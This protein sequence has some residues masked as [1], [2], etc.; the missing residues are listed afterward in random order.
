MVN[1]FHRREKRNME[2]WNNS[3]MHVSSELSKCSFKANRLY[4]EPISWAFKYW[5]SGPREPPGAKHRTSYKEALL[6]ESRVKV[7]FVS[8]AMQREQ[9]MA[10]ELTELGLPGTIAMMGA[11]ERQNPE[12]SCPEDCGV[13]LCC[14]LNLRIVRKRYWA[15]SPSLGRLSGTHHNRTWSFSSTA[16]GIDQWL[17]HHSWAELRNAAC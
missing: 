2:K 17:S 11:L 15:S 7:D 3:M 8:R 6:H 4:S 16:A 9:Q 14:Y 10:L 12:D 13:L 5:H 1:P